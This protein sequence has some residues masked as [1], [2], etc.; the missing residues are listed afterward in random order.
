[1][2]CESGCE[3]AESDRSQGGSGWSHHVQRPTQGTRGCAPSSL[4]METP[5]ANSTVTSGAGREA[6]A[7]EQGVGSGRGEAQVQRVQEASVHGRSSELGRS[8]RPP[9]RRRLEGPTE[10][11]S[12]AGCKVTRAGSGRPG[13]HVELGGGRRKSPINSQQSGVHSPIPARYINASNWS[14]LSYPK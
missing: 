1:M 5:T 3:E 12:A 8:P 2:F 4:Q 10:G 7:A 14:L 9:W 6:R 11:G 13:T